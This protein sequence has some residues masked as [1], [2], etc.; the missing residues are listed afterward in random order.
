MLT[1]YNPAVKTKNNNKVNTNKADVKVKKLNSFGSVNT[2]QPTPPAQLPIPL[3]QDLQ[4]QNHKPYNPHM[5][6]PDPNQGIK[7]TDLNNTFL[8]QLPP[9]GSAENNEDLGVLHDGFDNKGNSN[10]AAEILEKRRMKKKDN[11]SQQFVN[12]LYIP[13]NFQQESPIGAAPTL[14]PPQ[15]MNPSFSVPGPLPPGMMPPPGI[16][17]NDVGMDDEDIALSGEK[18]KRIPRKTDALLASKPLPA[19]VPENY[20]EAEFINSNADRTNLNQNPIPLGQLANVPSPPPQDLPINITN[21]LPIIPQGP[22]LNNQPMMNPGSMPNNQPLGNNQFQSTDPAALGLNP[23]YLNNASQLIQNS[24]T[25]AKK[26]IT[27]AFVIAGAGITAAAGFFIGKSK[28]IG[29]K[30]NMDKCKSFTGNYLVSTTTYLNLATEYIKN[31]L[32][33]AANGELPNFFKKIFKISKKGSTEYLKIKGKTR[34]TN[35]DEI[36]I[37]LKYITSGGCSLGKKI[38]IIFPEEKYASGVLN[39][40]LSGTISNIKENLH[41]HFNFHPNIREEIKGIIDSIT[42]ALPDNISNSVKLSDIEKAI[43]KAAIED[44]GIQQLK[45]HIKGNSTIA[46][47]IGRL[48][49]KL[50]TSNINFA[51]LEESAKA[52]ARYCEDR[53]YD[54]KNTV[55]HA[56]EI[57]KR[58]KFDRE[59]IPQIEIVMK[60]NRMREALRRIMIENNGC[61]PSSTDPRLIG[62]VTRVS[63]NLEPI[64][65]IEQISKSTSHKNNIRVNV[66]GLECTIKQNA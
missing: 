13:P 46:D 32:S 14:P 45:Q 29:I 1:K 30:A 40:F 37:Y 22:S 34:L 61:I 66:N 33:N 10:I 5:P 9:S 11:Q 55:N 6:M 63:L 17:G 8:S 56:V 62:D 19:F 21:C 24:A 20:P 44:P 31:S 57:V 3:H 16:P 47:N 54:V 4:L 39:Q 18:Q 65:W 64:G 58:A 50:S 36:G 42:R 51:E 23:A 48:K 43:S 38:D 28:Q 27:T 26:R 15:N 12:S 2:Q 35:P 41:K 49:A 60:D 59:R 25:S 7:R 52:G 53:L